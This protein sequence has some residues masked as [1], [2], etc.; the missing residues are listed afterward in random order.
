MALARLRVSLP[1]APVA[2]GYVLPAGAA[3]LLVLGA[4]A[5]QTH[6]SGAVV[7]A[8]AAVVVGGCAVAGTASGAAVAAVIGWLTVSGFSRAPYAELQPR[9]PTVVFVLAAAAVA[10]SAT[11][12]GLRAV[13]ASAVRGSTLSGMPLPG[14]VGASLGRARQLTG[15]LLAAVALPA[16]TAGLV[17]ARTS[18]RLVDDLLLYLLVVV[19]VTLVGG[20]WPAVLAAVAAGLLLNWFFVLPLHT[21]AVDQWQNLLALLLFVAVAVAVSSAVHLAARRQE[22]AHASGRETETLLDLAQTVL[23]GADTPAQVLA[24]LRQTLGLPGDLSERSGDRWATV[25]TAGD[26]DLADVTTVG[27]RDGLLLRVS[28]AGPHHERLLAAFAAQAAAALDRDRLRAQA[29]QAEALAAGNRMRTALLSAVSHDLRTPLASVKAAVSSLR[30]DDISWSPADERELLAT[31]EES[32]DRL[33]ALVGNLLDMSRLQTGALHPY[34]RPTSLEEVVPL[35]LAGLDGAGRVLLELPDDLPLVLTDPGLLDRVLGNLLANALRFS[36]ADRPPEVGANVGD[37]RVVLT[38]TDHGPGV[39]P[40]ARERIFEPFQRLGDA[41]AGVGLG[42]A[43]AKGF[44]D[45]MGV[46]IEVDETAGGG[47]TVALSLRVAPA[48]VPAGAA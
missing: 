46:P 14:R 16:L 44:C 15:L 43:V 38:V 32:A 35:A 18:L 34:L 20:F 17:A 30:Q 37:D 2:A 28:G 42:L 39:A 25:A 12:Y 4:V 22:Q 40:S 3:T 9:G 27:I 48:A 24:H 5:A 47:L 26:V 45:A 41:G 31:I 29:A 36:P 33:D 21:F 19:I 6:P 13:A 11:G 7:L 10:G 8:V 1:I 23:A